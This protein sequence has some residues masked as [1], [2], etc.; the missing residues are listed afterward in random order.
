[1]KGGRA[2]LKCVFISRRDT[3]YQLRHG[4]LE[5]GLGLDLWGHKKRLRIQI[6]QNIREVVEDRLQSEAREFEA[7]ASCLD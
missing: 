6:R 1:M 4:P 5:K 7:V 2:H 3:R